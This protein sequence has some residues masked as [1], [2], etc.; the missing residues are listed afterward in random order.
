MRKSTGNMYEFVT[1]T[2]NPVSGKCSHDC[3]YCYMKKWGELAPIHINESKMK[4]NLGEGNFIFVCSGCDLFARDIPDRYIELVA[5][6]AKIFDNRY[7]WH[8]KN[9]QRFFNWKESFREG[10]VLCVTMETNIYD[11]R[12]M[13]NA[14]KIMDRF[15]YLCEYS[16]EKMITIEPIM[17]FDVRDFASI[18]IDAR[19]IQVNIGADSGKNN[20]PEPSAEKIEQLIRAIEPFT[21]V[22]LKKNL[23]RLMA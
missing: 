7:L 20:L 8:T 9:P 13:N 22:H 5:D 3:S 4:A 18:I 15:S 23:R 1:H 19:P 11:R 17:D 21:K 6:R 12:Y 2:W 10:D 14:P 16:G